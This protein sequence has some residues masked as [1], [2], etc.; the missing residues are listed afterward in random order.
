MLFLCPVKTKNFLALYIN[1]IINIQTRLVNTPNNTG[2][3]EYS[4]EYLNSILKVIDRINN[5]ADSVIIIRDINILPTPEVSELLIISDEY[6]V[7]TCSISTFSVA[8]CI[9]EKS[10]L[11]HSGMETKVIKAIKHR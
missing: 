6:D 4:N 8:I 10:D 11:T 7:F 9:L 2:G 5:K 1:A 3:K